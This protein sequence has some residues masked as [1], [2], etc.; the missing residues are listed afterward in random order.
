[1]APWG[2]CRSRSSPRSGSAR[3]RLHSRRRRLLLTNWGRVRSRRRRRAPLGSQL[4]SGTPN[5]CHCSVGNRGFLPGSHVKGHAWVAEV[6][7]FP[8][9]RLDQQGDDRGPVDLTH[10]FYGQLRA[11]E[12]WGS[13]DLGSVR[14]DLVRRRSD[15]R[16]PGF[17]TSGERPWSPGCQADRV[18]RRSTIRRRK[19]RR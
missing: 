16:S 2:P 13:R 9:R 15:R 5:G 6:V 8:L 14:L 4:A 12:T 3:S 10:G 18:R 17:R 11:A 1:M 19:G 7:A